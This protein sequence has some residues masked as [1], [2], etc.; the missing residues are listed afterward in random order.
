MKFISID[1]QSNIYNTLLESILRL[2]FSEHTSHIINSIL[3]IIFFSGI[4]YVVD[5]FF[6]KTFHMLILSFVRRTKTKFDDYLIQN[7][8]L[9]NLTHFIPLVIAKYA[10]PIIFSGFPKWTEITLKI[11]YFLIIITFCLIING[12]SKSFRDIL[13]T[14]KSFVDKP[15]DS[16]FQV[17]SIV[18]FSVGGIII[19]SGLTGKTPYGFLYSLGAASAIL[20]L[21][22]KDTILGFIAS[23]QVS[24]ND[25]V[26]VGDWVSLPKYNADGFV[27]SMNLNTVKVQNWDKTI[28]TIP[29]YAFIND[30]FVNWRGMFDSGGRRIKR[31]IYFKISS[32]SFCDKEMI[33]KFKNYSLIREYILDKEKEIEEHN[34]KLAEKSEVS[35]NIRR[36]TN[37]GVFRIYAENYIKENKNINPNM[38]AM[39]R[40]LA[41]TSKGLPLEIYCFTSDT[42]WIFHEKICAD[43]FDHLLTVA[44]EFGLEVFEEPS[45]KD[46]AKL[47]QTNDI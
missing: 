41:P 16:Y 30:S 36:L 47:V 7:N 9:R 17:V 24:V 15:L 34:T 11:T 35:V 6:R 10:L 32:F 22:F 19:I 42:R 4:L 12:I 8:V 21:I 37:I 38:T 45:G 39:V 2:G 33:D 25:M 31:A 43:I 3:L 13:K 18:I 1:L 27:L 40:Q 28:S 23:I 20:M 14:N 44:Y 46:F 5:V 26:R 29:T